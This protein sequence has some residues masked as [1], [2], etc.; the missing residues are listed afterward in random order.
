MLCSNE[1]QSNRLCSNTAVR[2][3][4][5]RKGLNYTWRVVLVWGGKVVD[6]GR[7]EEE[8]ESAANTRV[9][10]GLKNEKGERGKKKQVGGRGG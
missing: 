1:L 4:V 7:G 5:G 8:K 10:V 2:C 9:G 6:A 3:V